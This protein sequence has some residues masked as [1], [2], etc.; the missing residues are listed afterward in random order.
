M[1]TTETRKEDAA[2]VPEKATKQDFNNIVKQYVST[3][4]YI[5]SGHKTNELEIR[6]GT[7]HRLKRPIT[8]NNYD[9]VIQKL[10]S[11]GFNAGDTKGLQLLRIQSEYIDANGRSRMSNV[12]AE[13]VGNDMIQ[14]YCE[15][16]D[17]SKLINMPSTL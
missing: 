17:I 7:N 16:N 14:K 15:T 13:I 11:C 10:N 6:F 3:N 4:P 12:R 1:S 9:N 8:K 2:N 5:S